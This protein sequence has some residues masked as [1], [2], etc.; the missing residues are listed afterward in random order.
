MLCLGDYV[1]QTSRPQWGIGG[2][3]SIGDSEK[4]AIFFLQG[5]K[6]IFYSSSPDLEQV[7][8]QHPILEIAGSVNCGSTVSGRLL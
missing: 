2:V 4:V 5:G 3:I 7:D 1:K 8:S 6:R